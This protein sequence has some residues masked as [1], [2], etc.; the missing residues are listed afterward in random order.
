MMGLVRLSL[1]LLGLTLGLGERAVAQSC[2]TAATG[3]AFSNYQP[4]SGLPVTTTAQVT[5]TCSAT[6]AIGVSYSLQISAGTGGT[7]ANRSM[8]GTPSGRLPYQIYSD[9]L[10]SQIWGDG[11]GGSSAVNDGY[12]LGI[13][14][15]VVKTYFAYGRILANTNAP[16]GTYAD[17]ISILVVY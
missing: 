8:A 15:P 10:Y 12:L 17:T 11:T 4:L 3:L 14:F 16:V 6:I 1:I 2:T 7:Y 13:L 9:A 5:V